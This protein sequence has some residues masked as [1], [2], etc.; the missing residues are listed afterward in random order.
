LPPE[1]APHCGVAGLLGVEKCKNNTNR[2]REY[3]QLRKNIGKGPFKQRI[4]KIFNV[5]THIK[6]GRQRDTT[7]SKNLTG[8]TNIHKPVKYIIKN[9]CSLMDWS[10]AYKRKILSIT[11]LTLVQIFL[12]YLA[13]TR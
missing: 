7:L 9:A 5:Y 8:Q 10:R 2:S 11:A 13:F 4:L 6:I 3:K 12:A 1:P